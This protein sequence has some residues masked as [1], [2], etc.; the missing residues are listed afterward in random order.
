MTEDGLNRANHVDFTFLEKVKHAGY[1][2]MIDMSTV[3]E[4]L[5]IQGIDKELH[6]R[7]NRYPL[8]K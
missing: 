7:W 4:H 1:D 2:I 8:S 3:V 6:K 5:S